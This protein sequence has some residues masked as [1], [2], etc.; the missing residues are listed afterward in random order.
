LLL[1]AVREALEK[2][3]SKGTALP[4]LAHALVRAVSYMLT[5]EAACDMG[6]L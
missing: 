1:D 4:I 5:R 2:Q 6:T 3:H